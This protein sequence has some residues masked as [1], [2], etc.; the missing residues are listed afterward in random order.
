MVSVVLKSVPDATQGLVL[1][2]SL[3]KMPSKDEIRMAL[4]VK[5]CYAPGADGISAE[6]LRL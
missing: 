4:V 6:L 2:D 1:S 3:V 5:N